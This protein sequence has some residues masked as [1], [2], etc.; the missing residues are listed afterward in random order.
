MTKLLFAASA[1]AVLTVAGHIPAMAQSSATGMSMPMVTCRD[2]TTM[3]RD[4]ARSVVFYVSGFQ[5]ASGS[6]QAGMGTSGSTTTGTTGTTGSTTTDTTGTTGSTAADAGSGTAGSTTTDTTGTSGSTAAD[7]GSG[8]DAT[9]S[10]STAGGTSDTSGA[11]SGASGG[12][13]SAVIAQLP[14]FSSIDIDRVMSDC[15]S[16]PDKQLSEVIGMMG[17]TGSTAQ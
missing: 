9:G 4:M 10:T 3:D 14:G 2:L 12:A 6:M 5:A 16:S 7:A 11:A 1:A 13:S 15:A 17:G 8:T